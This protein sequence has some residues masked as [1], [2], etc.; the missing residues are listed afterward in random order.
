[1]KKNTTIDGVEILRFISAFAIL[2]WHYQHFNYPITNEIKINQ[3]LYRYLKFFYVYGYMGV[4]FFWCISGFIFFWKY[5]DKIKELSFKIFFIAR[6]SRLYP[7]HFLTLLLVLIFQN[8]FFSLNNDFFIVKNNDF[9]HFFLQIFM[10]S[11]WG[12]ENGTSFNGVIW[13]ISIEI[14]IY[15]VFFSHLKFFQKKFN[16]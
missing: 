2:V 10:A 3:P 8:I 14:L 7:L 5:G 1:M 6:F 4:Y 13:S 12:F 15:G 9:Y 16:N 11:N